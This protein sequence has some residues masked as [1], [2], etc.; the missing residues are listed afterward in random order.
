KLTSLTPG[1]APTGSAAITLTA[2]GSSFVAASVVRWNGADRPTT[3][4]S[5]T[6]L[7]AAIPA[8]DLAASGTAQV[9]VF[10]PAPGGGT[11]SALPFTIGGSAALGA[12]A[13]GAHGGAPAPS[14]EA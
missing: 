12:S 4:V 2:T 11:S 6:Q 8:S 7:T 1:G 9:T 5:G 13:P 14:P 10:T 3:F